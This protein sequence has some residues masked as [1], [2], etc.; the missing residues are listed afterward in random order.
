MRRRVGPYLEQPRWDE[1]RAP[2]EKEV[3]M[4]GVIAI[5]LDT[6]SAKISD[7][8]YPEDEAEDYAIPVWAGI[9]PMETRYTKLRDAD[10]LIEGVAPSAAV[11]A[12]EGKKL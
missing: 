3:K 10:R 9:L 2:L 11:R 6:A 4:T 12:L 1:L 7:K 8:P 5:D